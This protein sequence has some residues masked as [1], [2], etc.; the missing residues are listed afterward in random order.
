MLAGKTF[1]PLYV[2]F[3][4]KAAAQADRHCFLIYIRSKKMTQKIMFFASRFVGIH[5]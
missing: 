2:F 3:F 5:R 4:I 1:N